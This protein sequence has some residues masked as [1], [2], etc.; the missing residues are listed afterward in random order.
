MLNLLKKQNYNRYK[1]MVALVD[2]EHYPQV[3]NDAL[4]K[5]KKEFN[6][7]LAGIIFLGGTEKI[8]SGKFSDFFD[9]EVFVIKNIVKDFTSALDKFKPDIV[10]DLSDQ[11]VVNHDIRMKIASFCFY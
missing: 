9:Y 5:L 3:T 8:S 1:R 6:G 7:E 4:K 10:F 11:P 2:G